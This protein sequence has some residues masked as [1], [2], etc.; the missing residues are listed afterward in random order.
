MYKIR[1][2]EIFPLS[3]KNATRFIKRHV[4]FRLL[5]VMPVSHHLRLL[6]SHPEGCQ[7]VCHWPGDVNCYS[8]CGNR[9]A[10]RVK[11]S[12][13]SCHCSLI[14]ERCISFQ[15]ILSNRRGGYWLESHAASYK[16]KCTCTQFEI[17]KKG[18]K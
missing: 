6:S 18:Q 2:L 17:M 12:A 5:S 11:A 14:R 1:V 13:K 16:L 4:V 8:L 7:Q 15:W 10:D 9:M 3:T